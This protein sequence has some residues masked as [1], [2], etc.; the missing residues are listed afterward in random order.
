M[1]NKLDTGASGLFKSDSFP[2]PAAKPTVKGTD[3]HAQRKPEEFAYKLSPEDFR[4]KHGGR[5]ANAMPYMGGDDRRRARELVLAN[6]LIT[7]QG[8]QGL[9]GRYFNRPPIESRTGTQQRLLDRAVIAL[10]ALGVVAGI[11]VYELS[12]VHLQFGNDNPTPTT[13]STTT[14]TAPGSLES[15]TVPPVSVQLDPNSSTT[16][17]VVTLPTLA[18]AAPEDGATSTTVAG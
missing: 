13:I 11:G 5:F 1:A 6:T 8:K 15:T 18:P 2:G 16:T 12:D 4:K 9:V 7:W 14:T 17:V 10:G 3:P